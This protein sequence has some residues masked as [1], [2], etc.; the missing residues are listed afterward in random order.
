M[1]SVIY[2]IMM[3][4]VT[5]AIKL[6]DAN[7]L[8]PTVWCAVRPL[9]PILDRKGRLITFDPRL[10]DPRIRAFIE[11]VI[12][13]LG[14]I[15]G[16]F[17]C[18]PPLPF[19]T[20]FDK[21]FNKPLLII[22][23]DDYGFSEEDGFGYTAQILP[24]IDGDDIGEIAI[25]APLANGRS[26]VLTIISGS[27][28]EEINRLEGNS[29]EMLG[30]S[31]TLLD[32]NSLAVG[33]LGSG[34]VYLINSN[35]EV[36]NSLS[37]E[38]EDGFGFA[39]ANLEDLDGDGLAELAIGAPYAENNQGSVHI[40]YGNGDLQILAN[41]NNQ[42]EK[43]GYALTSADLDNDGL[44]DLLIGSYEAH[45]GKGEVRAINFTGEEL[46]SQQGIE[47]EQFGFSLTSYTNEETVQ[48]LVGA[49]SWQSNAGRAYILGSDG[50]VLGHTSTNQEGSQLGN[51]VAITRD[52]QGITYLVA[53]ASS[54]NQSYFYDIK[55][56]NF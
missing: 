20:I 27:T 32:E 14:P 39:L 33:A 18:P 53:F 8:D 10:G 31:L 54:R 28:G 6:F 25:A 15:C 17:D 43:F 16:K 30:S 56:G 51:N 35:L 44:A 23:A 40:A 4:M 13:D 45:E 52:S 46:W 1:V 12:P 29:D 19:L 24:D 41:G 5:V 2:V 37:G 47:D 3:L 48:I 36:E 49:P 21:D 26:G 38:S 34:S 55:E 9:D 11:G 50:N 7:D 42:G 22:G